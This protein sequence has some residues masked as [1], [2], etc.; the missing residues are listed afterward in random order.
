M[1]KQLRQDALIVAGVLALSLVACVAGSDS[2]GTVRYD[3]SFDLDEDDPCVEVYERLMAATEEGGEVATLNALA[4]ELE[5]C[6]GPGRGVGVVMGPSGVA[7]VGFSLLYMVVPIV[8]AVVIGNA[9]Y[10]AL[11]SIVRRRND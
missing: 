10:D 9:I 5:E 4:A 1:A 6:S 11:R 7:G 8:V 3:T 2:N